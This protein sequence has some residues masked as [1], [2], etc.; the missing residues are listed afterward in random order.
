MTWISAALGLFKLKLAL[1]AGAILITLIGGH[2]AF[3][4]WKS[5]LVDR[6]LLELSNEQH[7]KAIKVREKEIKLLNETSESMRKEVAWARDYV[8]KSEKRIKKLKAKATI[9]TKKCFDTSISTDYIK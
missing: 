2:L 4:S 3:Q 6:A 9:E 5:G 7:D 8:S 1:Y